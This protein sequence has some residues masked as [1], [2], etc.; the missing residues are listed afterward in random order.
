MPLQVK[1]HKVSH[2]KD[3]TTDL[4]PSSGHGHFENF[5]LNCNVLKR[6]NSAFM[7]IIVAVSK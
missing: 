6:P 5:I 2:W 4:E 7:Y 1:H 3:M